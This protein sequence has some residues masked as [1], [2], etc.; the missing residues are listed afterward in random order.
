M[1][2]YRHPKHN[3]A[4]PIR[5]RYAELMW[6]NEYSEHQTDPFFMYFFSW[7]C[8]QRLMQFCHLLSNVMFTVH[9]CGFV[10]VGGWGAGA[11]LACTP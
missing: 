10:C 3:H 5:V 6:K 1:N 9:V 7:F 8:I 2:W 4:L 11:E